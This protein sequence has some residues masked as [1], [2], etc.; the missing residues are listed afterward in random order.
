[1]MKWFGT[2]HGFKLTRSGEATC[3]CRGK[4]PDHRTLLD[5]DMAQFCDLFA[6]SDTGLD[7]E[8]ENPYQ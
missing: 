3:K 7:N 6:W 8:W 2:R 5:P 4:N 1:M